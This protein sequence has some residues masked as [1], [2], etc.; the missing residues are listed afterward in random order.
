VV[1]PPGLFARLEKLISWVAD[2]PW[3]REEIRYWRW[4]FV[5]AGRERRMKREAAYH[6]A[7]MML[8]D[9]P[10]ECG[11]DMVKKDYDAVERAERDAV[12]R[13]ERAERELPF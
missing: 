8:K 6:H 5:H 1:L 9:T 2:R 13:A 10:A 12:E 11:R 4:H 3:S 7:V